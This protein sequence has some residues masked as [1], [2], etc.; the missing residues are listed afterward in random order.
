MRE[1]LQFVVNEIRCKRPCRQASSRKNTNPPAHKRGIDR[2]VWRALE[3]ALHDGTQDLV[4]A[5]L[6]PGTATPIA[7]IPPLALAAFPPGELGRLGFV[8]RGTAASEPPNKLPST[9]RRVS[10]SNRIFVHRDPPDSR[11]RFF[12]RSPVG[13]GIVRSSRW[14]GRACSERWVCR[15][16]SRTARRFGRVGKASAMPQAPSSLHGPACEVTQAEVP[17]LVVEQKQLGPAPQPRPSAPGQ[18]AG[19][20]RRRRRPCPRSGVVSGSSDRRRRFASS[21]G[22]ACVSSASSSWSRLHR[23]RGARRAIP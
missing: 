19:P 21:G 9:S 14:A 20:R 23:D 4:L 11:V 2:P 16:G 15:S 1:M 5:P 13:V 3:R 22:N 18:T 17:R 10:R 8:R 7:E 12:L 6:R